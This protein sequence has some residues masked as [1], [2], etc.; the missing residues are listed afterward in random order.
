M[1]SFAIPDCTHNK[2]YAT[3]FTTLFS[4]GIMIESSNVIQ[5]HLNNYG[6]E[7]IIF[8][9]LDTKEMKVRIIDGDGKLTPIA[10]PSE[11][12]EMDTIDLDNSGTRW[13]GPSWDHEPFGFGNYFNANGELSYTGFMINHSI[14]G[15]GTFYFPGTTLVKYIG[16]HI[17]GV[18]SGYGKLYDINGSLLYEGEWMEGSVLNTFSLSESQLTD[19]HCIH[20]QLESV[21]IGDSS[22]TDESVTI[23]SFNGYTFEELIIGDHCFPNVIKVC[24]ISCPNIHHL[25]VGSHSFYPGEDV[26]KMGTFS[27]IHCPNL[28]YLCFG[29]YACMHFMLSIEGMN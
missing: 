15:F 29:P 28:K 1:D 12:V 14:I 22:F 27:L 13:E 26:V 8:C 11:I 2:I 23:V 20:S 10:D 19:E 25:E 16:T 6:M 4:R 18:Y 9:L 21:K 24:I 5:C 3:G 7:E 17:K